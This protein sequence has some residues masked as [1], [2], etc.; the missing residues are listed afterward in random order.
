MAQHSKTSRGS[1]PAITRAAAH[2]PTT[3]GTAP[4]SRSA[5][6]SAATSPERVV[7]APPSPRPAAQAGRPQRA[8][9]VISLSGAA[10]STDEY[11]YQAFEALRIVPTGTGW[12]D[13]AAVAE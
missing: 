11:R 9:P 12:I 1:N 7:G 5:A 2:T 3:G 4:T 8:A 6:R 10:R 13:L